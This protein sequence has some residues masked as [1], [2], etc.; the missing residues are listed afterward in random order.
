MEKVEHIKEGVL[1]IAKRFLDLSIFLFLTCFIAQK[2]FKVDNDFIGSYGF[3]KE[4]IVVAG[5]LLIIYLLLT[6]FV[7]IKK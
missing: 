7:R 1:V 4:S 6:L 3:A 2:I 5:I